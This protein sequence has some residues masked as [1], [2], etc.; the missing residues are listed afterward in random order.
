MRR[1]ITLLISFWM[2]SA[3]LFAAAT[4]RARQAPSASI[5]GTATTASGQPMPNTTVQLRDTTTGQLAGTTRTDRSGAFRFAGLAAGTYLIETLG[6]TG[7]IVGTSAAIT[8]TA[9]GAVTGVTVGA[10]AGAVAG[11][12]A[13]AAGGGISTAVIVS[14]IAAAA[15]VAGAVAVATNG[16]A[17]ASR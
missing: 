10:A 4:P 8:V 17:S 16:T 1:I 14:T 5:S 13:G 7:Q 3:P 12:V 9:A 6:A 15:G 11:V 2:I